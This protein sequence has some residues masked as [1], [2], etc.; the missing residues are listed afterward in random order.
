MARF[1]H[2]HHE[3]VWVLLGKA[4]RGKR[5]KKTQQ[6]GKGGWV[7]P[8]EICAGEPKWKKDKIRERSFLR[9]EGGGGWVGAPG[10]NAKIGGDPKIE[11]RPLRGR[12]SEKSGSAHDL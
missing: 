10:K 5:K 4:K 9:G 3:N 8:E 12:N 6:K 2:K 1:W 7:D 11:D